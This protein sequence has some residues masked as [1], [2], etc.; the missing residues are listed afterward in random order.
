MLKKL[1]QSVVIGL[2]AA[3]LVLGMMVL[4]QGKA[5][6]LNKEDNLQVVSYAAAVR[7]ASP[8][9]VNVYNQ[10]LQ[11]NRGLDNPEQLRV[12]NLGSGVIMRA[13][14]Y[15]LTNRHV[16]NNADQIV[17]A[18]QNGRIYQAVLVGSDNLTDLAVLKIE[19]E[20]LPIIPQNKKRRVYVGD[21][22][23][24]IGNP[25]NLGQSVSQGIIS[26]TGRNAL[27]E[28]GRQNFI[29]TDASINRGNSGG[30]LIN[31]AGELVGINT[32][33]IGKDSTEIAEGLSFAIPI[34]IANDI[35][36]KIIQDGRVIR[37][38][39]GVESQI[40]YNNEEQLGLNQRGVLVTAVAANGP[41]S[42]AGILQGDLILQFNAK[43]VNEPTELLRIISD[44]KPGTIVSVQIERLGQLLNLPV[45][46]AEYPQ[47]RNE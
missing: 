11:V 36:K 31:T 28:I 47:Q 19:A 13:D 15:I 35:L 12:N 1:L 5:Y 45:T 2:C 4:W 14:G 40:F 10:S 26:A 39:F 6:L 43:A 25:Y 32:L 20:N 27:G 9:V 22:T 34:S 44:T 23:L 42:R 8:A 41:A 33:S 21:V 38:Y 46:I 29:Q 7:I 16:I 30:A 17:V 3:I 37:G 24:A 18:L